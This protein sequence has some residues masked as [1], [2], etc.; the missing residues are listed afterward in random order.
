MHLQS[1]GTSQTRGST[2]LILI[3]I[4]NLLRSP[5]EE[6][7]KQRVSL[8]TLSTATRNNMADTGE[9]DGATPLPELKVEE[10]SIE[11]GNPDGEKKELSKN[12]LKKLA[13]GKVCYV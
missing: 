4:H 9:K 3:I 5:I 7:S 12:A 2:S 11:D 1:A 13:K 6:R 8:K 10:M